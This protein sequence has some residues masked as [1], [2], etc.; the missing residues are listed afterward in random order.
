MGSVC[1]EC[2]I[3]IQPEDSADIR[4]VK[5][6]ALLGLKLYTLVPLLS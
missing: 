3:K 2:E 6:G 1:R 5:I 4:L